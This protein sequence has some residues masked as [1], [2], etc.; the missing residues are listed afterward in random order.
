MDDTRR[1]LRNLYDVT[2]GE[3]YGR[4]LEFEPEGWGNHEVWHVDADERTGIAYSYCAGG[5]WP[6]AKGCR[7]ETHG[8]RNLT[9]SELPE[10]P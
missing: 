10:E 4:W 1:V 6:V 5:R 8:C 2:G 9:V 7:P 3:T